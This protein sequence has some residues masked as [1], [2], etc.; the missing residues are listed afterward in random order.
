MRQL[1]EPQIF[2]KRV[3]SIFC[4]RF[5]INELCTTCQM[6][7]NLPIL[8]II[9]RANTNVE[10]LFYRFYNIFFTK[11]CSLKNCVLV[12]MTDTKLVCF[13]LSIEYKEV[14][15]FVC[16]FLVKYFFLALNYYRTQHITS[17]Q[18]I[19]I[20]SFILSYKMSNS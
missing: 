3:A 17:L 16:Y 1:D 5:G 11:L 8:K 20:F 18:H 4:E 14:Y 10:T 6:I 15:I 19:K 12:C 2:V 7:S 9:H 13:V